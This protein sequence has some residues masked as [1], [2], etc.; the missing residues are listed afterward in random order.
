MPVSF[1]ILCV[2]MSILFYALFGYMIS[3]FL[4]PSNPSDIIAALW[5][6]LVLMLLIYAVVS[7]LVNV[8]TSVYR[9]IASKKSRDDLFNEIF[10]SFK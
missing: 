3:S 8:F 7:V 9:L 4:N 1:I 6:L 10:N 5:P 2:F